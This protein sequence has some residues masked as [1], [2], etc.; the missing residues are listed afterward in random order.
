MDEIRD[1]RR[2]QLLR[3]L[4]KVPGLSFYE[5]ARHTKVTCAKNGRVTMIPR[6]RMVW[7]KTLRD[8]VQQL[9]AMELFDVDRWLQE[10]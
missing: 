7:A 10:L 6:H 8:I 4:A 9:R 1:I 2:K 3:A 5:G